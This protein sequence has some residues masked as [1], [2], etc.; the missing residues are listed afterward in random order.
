MTRFAQL[1]EDNGYA[2][3]IE[4]QADELVSSHYDTYEIIKKQ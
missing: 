3:I 2:G 1:K 4:T